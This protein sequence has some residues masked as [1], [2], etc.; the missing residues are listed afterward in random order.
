MEIIL[1]IPSELEYFEG[2]VKL[3]KKQ[4]WSVTIRPGGNYYINNF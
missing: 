3:A 1:T 4:K 2:L